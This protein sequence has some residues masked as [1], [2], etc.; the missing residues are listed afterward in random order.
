MGAGRMDSR[1]KQR[2]EKVAARARYLRLAK[3]LA[4]VWLCLAAMGAL[5]LWTSRQQD[6]QMGPSIAMGLA[7]VATLLVA[8][9]WARSLW[10]QTDFAVTARSIEEHYPTLNERL[11]AAMYQQPHRADGSFG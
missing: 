6:W 9:F 3:R 2:L 1:L 4:A 10:R 7:L 5:A 11:L 8:W